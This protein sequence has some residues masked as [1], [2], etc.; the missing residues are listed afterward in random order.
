[1]DDGRNNKNKR[2]R[3]SGWH[4]NTDQFDEL[5]TALN[6]TRREVAELIGSGLTPQAISSWRSEESI[7]FAYAN[8]LASELLSQLRSREATALDKRVLQL[9]EQA[10]VIS[11]A[12]GSAQPTGPDSPFYVVDHRPD[13]SRPASDSASKE[14]VDKD[15][16]KSAPARKG[17]SPLTKEQSDLLQ[18]IG[19]D[20]ALIQ[21]L[22]RRGWD[23]SLRLKGSTV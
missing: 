11:D 7:P 4:L 22:E 15:A 5:M 16:T 8:R 21:E 12:S 9:F 13:K 19:D 6:K 2:G 10:K 1:M 23:V 17:H 18:S 20:K 14:N 3:K